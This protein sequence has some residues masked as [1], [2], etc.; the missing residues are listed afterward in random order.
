MALVKVV[1][2]QHKSAVA[3]NAANMAIELRNAANIIRTKGLIDGTLTQ[4]EG[5]WAIGAAIGDT[6]TEIIT[7]E[8][9]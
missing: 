7:W 5:I 2:F 9:Q 8:G 1:Q 3:P 6:I 4:T